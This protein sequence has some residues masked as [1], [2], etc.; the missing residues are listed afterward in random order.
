MTI[1][2]S[3]H[4]ARE[5][6]IQGLQRK[7]LIAKELISTKIIDF[8]CKGNMV[9]FYL[10]KDSLEDYHGDDWNDVPYECNAGRV[11]RDFIS[12]TADLIFPYGDLVLEP[13]SGE[14]NTRY[15]KDDMKAGVV[16]C[17]I[18]VP[19]YLAK[20]SYQG[21]F[22]YWANCKGIHKFYMN[23]R[24]EPTTEPA[25]YYFDA[26]EH[27]LRNKQYN[28]F[29]TR[30]RDGTDAGGIAMNEVPIW[31]KANL[32]ITEAAAYFG[33]GQ[34]KLSELTKM[35]NCSFVLYIGNRRLIKRKQFEAFL[36]KQTFL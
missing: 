24:M 7:P 26:V 25:L 1:P 29:V 31:E 14:F 23:D 18:I 16:P 28:I 36:E 10:G 3:P 30:Q 4:R 9:R 8:E 2:P 33:I 32:T 27:T 15:S 13:C 35:R 5:A 19:E 34:N 6:I 12:G 11:Y 21:E 20:S 17:I 22:S